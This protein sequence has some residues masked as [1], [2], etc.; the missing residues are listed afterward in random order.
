MRT[1][2]IMSML[3]TF[4]LGASFAEKKLALKDLPLAVQ[5]AIQD[6]LKGG[7][8]KSIGKETEHGVAQYEVETM[9]EGKHRD[10]NVDTK[11]KLLV[12]EEETTIDSIPAA[13]RAGIMKKVADGKVGM[14][15]LF[16]RSGETLYEAEYT[17][18]AGRKHEVL[19]KADGT[20]TKE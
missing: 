2:T 12:V 1:L 3:L 20:E 11:G 14:V 16:L 4:S 18:K 13:A 9:R 5:K 19:V 7:E 17:T 6:E 10:F 15:E 8:I